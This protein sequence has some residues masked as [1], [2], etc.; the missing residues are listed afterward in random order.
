MSALTGTVNSIN[1]SGTITLGSPTADTV[2]TGNTQVNGLLI[3]T[4]VT[5]EQ[6]V[7]VNGT[8]Q[9]THCS[10]K[11]LCTV[12]GTINAQQ[13]TFIALDLYGAGQV[14]TA[15]SLRNVAITLP[16]SNKK[17]EPLQLID[18]KINGDIT[19]TPKDKMDVIIQGKT[20]IN[21]AIAGAHRLIRK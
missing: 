19:I 4:N 1:S 15:C 18:T 5:F 7:Q 3:A 14:F 17:P 10:C 13:T 12:S 16:T 11:Q 21:G 8:A 20:T 6:P 2:V 9:F